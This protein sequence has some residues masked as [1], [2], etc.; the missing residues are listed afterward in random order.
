[1]KPA[2][3]F[4]VPMTASP[5][6]CWRWRAVDGKAE[7]KSQFAH[8]HDCLADAQANGFVVELSVAQGNT[9]PGWRALTTQAASRC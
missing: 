4:S 9:A 2:V 3:I 1:M 7:S 6:Y 5:G 8:Y